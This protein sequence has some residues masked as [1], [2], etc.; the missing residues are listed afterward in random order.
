MSGGPTYGLDYYLGGDAYT[1]HPLATGPYKFEGDWTGKDRTL[2]KNDKWKPETDAGRHQYV[3]EF[4]FKLGLD[5]S[6]VQQRVIADKGADQT[7]L[8][9][10]NILADNYATIH[11]STAEKRLVIGPSPCTTYMWM[12][13]R[14][15]PLSFGGNVDTVH[16]E[17]DPHGAR[18]LA[19]NEG[20]DIEAFLKRWNHENSAP[21]VTKDGGTAG[22]VIGAGL[23]VAAALVLALK[24]NVIVQ[25]VILAIEIAQAIATAA[26]TF[27]A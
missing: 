8:T 14:K 25:L 23:F 11:G 1:R 12:D 3:D 22:M 19:E 4:V 17:A 21:K 24:I 18:V 26:V 16:A 20:L 2:V 9:Y 27:G 7:A 13:T 6:E 15:M 5:E 10:S